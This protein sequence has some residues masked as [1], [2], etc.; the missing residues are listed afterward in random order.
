[1]D[2]SGNKKELIFVHLHCNRFEKS[3]F[4]RMFNFIER[5]NKK[6]VLYCPDQKEMYRNAGSE[7]QKSASFIKENLFFHLFILEEKLFKT[8]RKALLDILDDSK[9]PVLVI[10]QKT[11][12]SIDLEGPVFMSLNH[13]KENKEKV[14]WSA[15]LCKA[16]ECPVQILAQNHSDRNLQKKINDNLF[17]A[18]KNLAELNIDYAVE[19][20]DKKKDIKNSIQERMQEKTTVF[21]FME[22]RKFSAFCRL[23]PYHF[24]SYFPKSQSALFLM[25][26]RDDLYLP[27]I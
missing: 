4:E 20:F 16:M 15:A 13:R 14:F 11:I 22:F 25:R 1:M 8:S 3:D 6:A 26:S 18:K 19:R 2:D 23:F 7:F 21:L 9:V 12:L 27:C 17:L 10:R 24:D 5:F